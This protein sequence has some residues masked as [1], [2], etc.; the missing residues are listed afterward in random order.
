M[1]LTVLFVAASVAVA[2]QTGGYTD[3]PSDH[4]AAPAVQRLSAA[5]YVPAAQ[6]RSFAGEKPVTRYEFAVVM[7][8]FITA[9]SRAFIRKPTKKTINASKIKGK[10]A[11]GSQAAMVRLAS[12]GY[13]PYYSPIFHGPD[14]TIT[15]NQLT[16]ALAQVSQRLGYSFRTQDDGDAPLIGQPKSRSGGGGS[17]S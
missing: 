5:G 17:G 10:V 13:L 16:V 2:S 11:D 1:S 4:W 3:V 8:K 9:M 7:D 6:E 15:P 12:E 14:D